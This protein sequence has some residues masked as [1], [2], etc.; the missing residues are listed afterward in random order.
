MG[1]DQTKVALA[2]ESV[3]ATTGT[4]KH[5]SFFVGDRADNEIQPRHNGQALYSSTA[6]QNLSHVVD[7][8]SVSRVLVWEMEEQVIFVN[9]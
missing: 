9:I 3:P 7:S 5:S 4:P 8:L 2:R 1:L 6:S